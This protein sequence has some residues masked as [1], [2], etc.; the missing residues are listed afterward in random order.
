MEMED[1]LLEHPVVQQILS[2]GK[3]CFKMM[4]QGCTLRLQLASN[5]GCG[6]I[7]FQ[8]DCSEL[9]FQQQQRRRPSCFA[10]YEDTVGPE[11]VATAFR[12]HLESKDLDPSRVAVTDQTVGNFLEFFLAQQSGRFC[13]SDEGETSLV[14]LLLSTK[15]AGKL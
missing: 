3:L 11:G 1:D 2:F 6:L 10:G 5:K 13:Q 9:A 14:A 15:L 12:Q 7:R 8:L 4:F